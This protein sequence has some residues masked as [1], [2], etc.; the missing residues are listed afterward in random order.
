MG[1]QDADFAS[2]VA[3]RWPVL[4]RSVVLLGAPG[5]VAED[6]VV[7]GLAR[8]SSG[9]TRV[10]RSDDVETHVY[11]A[12]I[13]CWHQRQRRGLPDPGPD[14]AE[15]GA[16]EG[17]AAELLTRL[18]A[19]SH[20]QREVLVLSAF[21]GLS[22]GQVADVLDLDED[23]VRRRV[24][25][26][27]ADER[28]RSVG[29]AIGVPPP[30]YPQI[31]RRSLD[32]RRH[33]RR[34]ALA[35]TLLALLVAGL[36][37][38]AVLQLGDGVRERSVDVVPEPN[39]IDLPW[40]AD[41]RLHLRSVIVEI[42]GLTD[43]TAVGDAAVYLDQD[44]IVG[45][46]DAEGRVIEVGIAVPG[47]DLLGSTEEGWA[48]WVEPGASGRLVVWDVEDATEVGG[49]RSA[50]SVRPIAIDAGLVHF[51]LGD[52]DFTWAPPDDEPERLQ[53]TGLVDVSAATR[54]YQRDDRIEIVQPVFQGDFL[55][56]G[57][58]G[59]LSWGGA[60]ALTREPGP[61]RP[62]DPYRPLLYDTRSGSELETGVAPG[63]RIVDA[64][65]TTRQEIVYLVAPDGGDGGPL[66][67]R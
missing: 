30:A 32:Q 39:P 60:F 3:A 2:Y 36:A 6:V 67:L 53:P 50:S 8:C 10:L 48:A 43:L 55:R 27:P 7:A 56:I 18:D 38:W 14:P 15:G 1:G 22:D 62:G 42:S 59:R 29:A 25:G 61:W 33:R 26:A 28:V 35:G 41:G 34:R 37:V 11:R 13:G 16:T 12:V 40:Y 46:V 20:G 47:S 65:F 21:A 31:T 4:V 58:G 9:W 54:V 64:A 66:V 44:G 23:A 51:G 17:S 52:R 5:A 57:V 63:E 49:L 19:L 24:D 45:Q